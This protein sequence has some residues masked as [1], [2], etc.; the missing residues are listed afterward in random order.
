VTVETMRFEACAGFRASDGDEFV[1]SCGW[2]D[3]DHVDVIG[4]LEAA[5]AARQRRLPRPV[6][7]PERQAS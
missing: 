1:C 5:R 6:A 3:E 4:E 7:I 2:L